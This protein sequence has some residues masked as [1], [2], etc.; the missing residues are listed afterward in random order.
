MPYWGHNTCLVEL[1]PRCRRPRQSEMFCPKECYR[2]ELWMY[3]S[4]NIKINIIPLRTYSGARHLRH[5]VLVYHIRIIRICKLTHVQ[6]V[7]VS[8]H[9]HGVFSC[10]FQ[11]C[12]QRA[13]KGKKQTTHEGAWGNGNRTKNNLNLAAWL[14][15]VRDDNPNTYISHD[16]CAG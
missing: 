2:Y 6:I 14:T 3:D 13:R 11:G 4:I 5:Y 15:L 10:F 1:V 12:T 16:R 9:R 7:Y 8:Y